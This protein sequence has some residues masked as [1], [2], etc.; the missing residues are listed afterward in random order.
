MIAA[1]SK[2]SVIGINNK[3]PWTLRGDLSLFAKKIPFFA[4]PW[5]PHPLEGASS[6]PPPGPTAR[7]P[8]GGG[9]SRVWSE[10]VSREQK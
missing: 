4:A 10:N 1:C 3:L 2:H 8:R 6:P 7:G 5:T 9:K